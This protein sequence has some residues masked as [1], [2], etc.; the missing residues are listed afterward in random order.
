MRRAPGAPAWRRL[1]CLSMLGSL[2]AAVL[3][4]WLQG[5][6]HAPSHLPLPLPGLHACPRACLTAQWVCLAC[7]ATE[8]ASNCLRRL[9]HRVC[10][11]CA[12][13]A[14]APA[15][16]VDLLATYPRERMQVLQP[17]LS[18]GQC[19]TAVTPRGI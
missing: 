18:P 8:A 15:G 6:S 19:S 9:L 5:L 3:C 2:A 13:S 14:D 11:A 1:A 12:D 4:N 17:M 7:C 16:L 10:A